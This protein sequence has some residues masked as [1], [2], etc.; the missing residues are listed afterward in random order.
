MSNKEILSL[1][2]NGKD[3]SIACPPEERGALENAAN[4][5]NEKIDSIPNKQ[6][7]LILA[8]LAL[9]HEC[10][11]GGNKKELSEEMLAKIESLTDRLKKTLG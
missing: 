9:A 11:D 2:I 6:N 3:I 5:L 7:N 10:L 8:S 1:R 4:Y